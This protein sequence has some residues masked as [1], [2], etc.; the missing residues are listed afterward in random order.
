MFQEGQLPESDEGQPL[1]F[2]E[3]LA[4]LVPHVVGQSWTG[5]G[6][7]IFV[8]FGAEATSGI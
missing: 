7:V 4:L 8:R 3:R 6:R 1:F 2:L 5:P